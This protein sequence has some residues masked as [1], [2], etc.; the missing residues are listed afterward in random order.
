MFHFVSHTEELT[1]FPPEVCLPEVRPPPK[2]RL[3]V[4]FAM[5][6][7]AP[8]KQ[9]YFFLL[10]YERMNLAEHLERKELKKPI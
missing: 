8:F 9:V 2:D 10:C 1:F 4:Y 7:A 6:P 5:T 3:S